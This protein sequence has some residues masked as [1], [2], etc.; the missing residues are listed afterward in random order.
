MKISNFNNYTKKGCYPYGRYFATIDVTTG[1][2]LWRKTVTR[3]IFRE[4][5]SCWW[6]FLEDG[7]YVREDF[8]CKG[9]EDAYCAKNG[10]I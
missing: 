3:E 10:D 6:K 7:E 9:L 2:W 8:R 4:C 1:F 5:L